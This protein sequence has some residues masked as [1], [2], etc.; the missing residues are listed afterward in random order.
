MKKAIVLILLLGAL[1]FILIKRGDVFSGGSQDSFRT[2]M[3]PG[4]SLGI[5]RHPPAADFSRMRG[6]VDALPAFDPSSSKGWQVDLRSRDLSDLDLTGRMKDL[7]FA[8][9]DSRTVWPKKL[10]AE[11]DPAKI[12]DL[13]KNPGLGIRSLHGRGITGKGVGIAIID[14]ILL[15]DHVEYKDRLRFY[16]EIHAGGD[17]AAMHGPAVASI[18]VGKTVGVA[19]EADLY[20][21]AETHGTYE[22]REFTFDFK[23]LAQS[24]DRILEIDKGLSNQR[25]IRVIS[26][27][28]GWDPRQKGYAEVTAAVERAKKIGIVVVSSSIFETYDKKVYFHGLGRDSLANPELSQSYQPGLWWKDSFYSGRYKPA[29]V[30]DALLVPMDSRCTASP[31]GDGDYVFYRQGGWSW[32]IPYI[33]GLYALACQVNPEITPEIFWGAAIKTGDSRE[34][35]AFR[36][37]PVE[38]EIAKEVAGRLDERIA[39]VTQRFKDIPL[40]K[41]MALAYSQWTGKKIETMS[42]TDFRVWAAGMLR[43]EVLANT[44]PQTL[45]AIVNPVRLIEALK[46]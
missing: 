20:Y 36:Q 24:I 25:K 12:M 3:N 7:A 19:P 17:D 5:V 35:P 1:G 46:K 10:P 23:Y 11:F 30:S 45:K 16:E 38:E 44:R 28:V 40:E 34:F 29:L 31:T 2:Q 21:I 15:V 4:H 8:D 13:G 22:S 37:I 14:Q 26:I 43:D 42:E 32:S 39:L 41:A 6:K 18:A 33:A 27:S 9:F